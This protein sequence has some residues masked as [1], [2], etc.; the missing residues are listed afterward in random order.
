MHVGTCLFS[1]VILLLASSA[2]VF[3]QPATR[4]IKLAFLN[5]QSGKGEV[6]LTGRPVLFADTVNCTDSSRPLNAWGV[7]FVQQALVSA[8]RNDTSIVALG[9]AEAWICGSAENVR[10]LLGWSNKTSA[11]NGVAIVARYG[12][13][14]PEVW[15]QLDTSRNPNPADTMWVIRV[16]VCADATCS[17]SILMYA[18][19]WYATG[20]YKTWGYDTQARQTVDFML[21]TAGAEPHVLIGDLNAWEGTQPVCGQNPINAGVPRLRSAGYI[22]AWPRIHGTQEGFTGMTNRSGC[23]Y[24]VGYTWKRIDYAWSSPGL[25]PIDII[26]FAV[27]DV[28]G[29]AAPSDHYG[30]IA[31]YPFPGSEPPLDTVPPS[32]EIRTPAPGAVVS[33]SMDIA[34]DASDD[35]GITRVEVLEDGILRHT[36]NWAPFT[37]TCDTTV[38]FDGMHTVQA[39]AFDAAGNTSTSTAHTIEVRNDIPPPAT[40]GDIV[41]Y[42]S[43]AT[44][45]AGRWQVVADA[46]AAG[47]ATIT[48]PNAGAA[49][50]TAALAAPR[51]YF[52]L[53]FRPTAGR[54]YRLWIRGRA[55]A[56]HWSNDSVFV[57]FSGSV[58]STGAP[59]FRIGTTAAT[60]V[61][62][63]DAVNA[64]V[65]G[66]GWQDNGYGAGVLGSL[67]YFDGSPQTIRVQT[68]EDGMSI[69][70]IVLSPDTYLAAAPGSLTRDATILPE[71]VVGDDLDEI[72]VW[73]SAPVTIAGAWR[74][75]TDTTAAGGIALTHPDQGAAKLASALAAPVNYVELTFRAEAGRPYRLWIRGRAD[76]NS[77][78]NDSVFVQFSGSVTAGGAPA[79]RIGTTGSTTVNLEDAWGAG[80]AGW[81]WQDNGWGTGVLGPL[82]RFETTGLQKV[83]IQTREDGFRFDQLV[84]SSARYRTESPGALRNDTNILER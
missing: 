35:V 12:F 24:P 22:D 6:G 40:E 37:V 15:Q 9:L 38:H 48:H 50:L 18:A 41:L 13:A 27:P 74:S 56:N 69:D 39:R 31:T 79:Y 59:S 78:A 10:T 26:R 11:R 66:W 53:T 55:A 65:S 45:I 84:L 16:P 82:I 7:G 5:I 4:P 54:P 30:I 61:N 68:R 49:K 63:E 20:T 52:E 29:D 60:T 71:T 81:G 62:L 70:Q 43:R 2:N 25:E 28:P 21:R 47:G 80:I 58:T 72:V 67:L 8:L 77:W 42:A 14:G 19:H 34:V 76:H 3:A 1:S 64:G 73:A 23:G 57:Q 36:L 83:R 44:T 51:D 17:R 46:G 32:V 33:G 75:V